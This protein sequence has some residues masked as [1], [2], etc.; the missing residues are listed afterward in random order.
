M[1]NAR[2][3]AYKSDFFI[4]NSDSTPTGSFRINGHVIGGLG[5]PASDEHA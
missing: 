2:I 5:A 4:E 3:I 1:L